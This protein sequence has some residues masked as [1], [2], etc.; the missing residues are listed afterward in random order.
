MSNRS[1]DD[2][3]DRYMAGEGRVL[4][5]DKVRG[6]WYFH[7]FVVGAGAAGVVGGLLAREPAVVAATTL[8]TAGVWTNFAALRVTV[9]EQKLH[10]QY[11]LF[12]PEIDIDAIVSVKP[13][14]YAWWKYGGK[15]IRFGLDG[16]VAYNMLGDKGQGVEVTYRTKR[17][18][19]RTILVS[20]TDP[21]ALAAAILEAKRLSASR[22]DSALEA[23]RED[24]GLSTA[25]SEGPLTAVPVRPSEEA[26]QAADQL[27]TASAGR[28]APSD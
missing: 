4:Y 7:A 13:G 3:E 27:A 21:E 5:R 12:G 15:G 1:A 26:A 20:A 25:P 19:T 11:G 28:D 24:A 14:K 6:P 23:A 2:Y 18:R 8:L 17:G 9:S 22:T 16:S 10:V